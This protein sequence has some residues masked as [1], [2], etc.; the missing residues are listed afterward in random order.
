MQNLAYFSPELAA[1]IG[2]E[3]SVIF[4]KLQWCVENPQMS[5]TIA[6]DGLK[7]IRN[8]IA[9]TNPRKLNNAHG[10]QIDWLGNFI[11]ATPGKLR[12][13]FARLEAIGLVIARK[14]RAYSWD[15]CKYYT[16]NYDK[17]T[18]LLEGAP[19]PICSK[20]TNRSDGN[21]H[22]DFTTAAKSYQDTF[23]DIPLQ[24]LERE[25][26]FEKNEIVFEEEKQDRTEEFSQEVKDR[27]PE[28]VQEVICTPVNEKEDFW[29]NQQIEKLDQFSATVESATP[30][31]EVAYLKAESVYASVE[32]A[33]EW[34]KNELKEFQEQLKAYG[35][36]SGKKNPSGWAYTIASNMTSNGVP[37]PYWDEFKA[38]VAI[39]TGD[40]REW[41]S[42]PGV[43]CEAVIQCLT[44]RFLS[45]PGTTPAKAA[46][47]V[48]GVLESPKKMETIW[49]TIKNRVVFLRDECRRLGKMGVEHVALDPW[50]TPKSKASSEEA[51][52]ALQELHQ[53]QSPQLQS[54]Q[55]ET[56]PIASEE[57][58][59]E[60]QGRSS[61][62]AA[63]VESRT[64]PE[65]ELSEEECRANIAMLSA[66]C[67]GE[68]FEFGKVE[69]AIDQES[70]PSQKEEVFGDIG[71]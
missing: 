11:W 13:I 71:W 68:K 18:E 61:A 46:I 29:V 5:G 33:S 30:K 64:A 55:P 21:E 69:R 4:S 40:R 38:G 42:E 32:S 9:C 57:S 16:I 59:E 2:V 34:D 26:A 6:H 7:M 41:E 14:L 28:P 66:M 50:L 36:K 25:G 48:G 63:V 54:S 45:E 8:P 35:T 23:S 31:V 67:R 20:P 43:P 52:S 51:I 3:E 37:S 56:L 65:Y 60:S 12:R 62:L 17:L 1:I 70:L 19:L 53:Y 27:S 39:G 10:K 24:N 49:Q 47:Q 15:Q 44:E 22:I 58:N